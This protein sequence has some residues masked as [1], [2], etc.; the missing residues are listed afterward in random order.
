M[1]IWVY[2]D[3]YNEQGDVADPCDGDS[4]GPLAIRRNGVWEL[5]G[6]L[7]V[8]T[9]FITFIKMVKLDVE[10]RSKSRFWILSSSSNID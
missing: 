5:V 10:S 6:V 9:I 2:T 7:E 4:G 8:R 3:T 1:D